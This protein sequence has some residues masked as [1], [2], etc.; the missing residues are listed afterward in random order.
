M[1]FLLT[2]S[3]IYNLIAVAFLL[4]VL[5]F[6][7]IPAMITKLGNSFINGKKPGWAVALYTFMLKVYFRSS[8]FYAMRGLAYLWLQ[9]Y[10]QAIQDCNKAISLKAKFH[11]A[12][13]YRGV[14]YTHLGQFKLAIE[15]FNR[16][17]ELLPMYAQ[18]YINRARAL[19]RLQKYQEALRDFER[20]LELNPNVA[21]V[22]N[23]R[24]YIRYRLRQYQE[25]LQ[26]FNRALAIA[27]NFAQ[28]SG[29][30]G[31][32][33]LALKEYPLALQD[34]NHALA[35]K[36]DDALY[37]NG[38]GAVYRHLQDYQHALQDFEHAIA[39]APMYASSYHNRGTVSLRLH[40]VTQAKADFRKSQELDPRSI[41]HGWM[42][43]ACTLCFESPDEGMPER[44]DKLA[45]LNITPRSP[46]YYVVHVCRGW[47]YWLRG[48]FEEAL[49][50]FEQAIVIAPDDEIIY[51]WV[52]V[53]CAALGRDE[54]A[55]AAL[56]HARK[57]GAPDYMFRMLR[58]L[59][60]IRPDFLQQYGSSYLQEQ[61]AV[62]VDA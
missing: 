16:A 12:Y 36:P 22:Y 10:Q 49:T 31:L 45:S 19:I 8:L 2:T 46:H 15:D 35:R 59:E 40:N 37:Y 9:K 3:T 4:Y 30:R 32:V 48:H 61:A 58:L 43:E 47:A 1:G 60:K 14:A 41:V 53:A 21:Q 50:E 33:Y 57:E 17:I 42:S 44:L 55:K 13:D 28:A 20:A 11:T 39:L 24:G 5:F 29:N 18:A 52:G 25:A 6:V 51:I 23:E 34:F 27:P 54:E 26:D 7:L 56:E 62:Q 38:R